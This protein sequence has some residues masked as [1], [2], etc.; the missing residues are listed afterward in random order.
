MEEVGVVEEE[1]G[2][3]DGVVYPETLAPPGVVG[4]NPLVD[5]GDGLALVRASE[6]PHSPVVEDTLSPA[7]PGQESSPS[8]V[9]LRHHYLRFH[10]V[11]RVECGPS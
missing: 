1:E 11:V 4:V 8:H 6:Q 9:A 3:G 10:T 7:P 2:G 5:Q